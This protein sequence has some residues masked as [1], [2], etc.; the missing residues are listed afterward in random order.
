MD[1]K[2]LRQIFLEKRALVSVEQKRIDDE[3]LNQHLIKLVK[4]MN[5]K[6]VHVF[7]PMKS[8]P[9]IYPFIKEMLNNNVNVICPKSLPGGVMENYLLSS[10]MEV[11]KGIFGT[12]YPISPDK[13]E[14]EFDLIVI[15]GLAYNENK[16]RL[17]YGGGYYD[18]FLKSHK[19]TLK[20][21]PA[22]DFQVVKSLPSEAHDIKMDQII[23][24]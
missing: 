20:I 23:L 3:H 4:E 6:W 18:R 8:E 10:K 15:P 11:Q 13:Y 12:T 22:Y 19:S 2:E 1:K 9:N 7:L 16:D 24:P 17:G 5:S 14:G 21:A